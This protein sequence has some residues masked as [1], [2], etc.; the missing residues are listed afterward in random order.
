MDLHCLRA[1]ERKREKVCDLMLK[2]LVCNIY[3]MVMKKGEIGNVS[4]LSV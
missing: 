1:R 3:L 2:E 4:Y